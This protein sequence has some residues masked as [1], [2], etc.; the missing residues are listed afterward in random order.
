M[1]VTHIG[2]ALNRLGV[3]CDLEPTD[4]ICSAVVVLSIL[5]EGDSNPRLTIANSEGISWV[6][7]SGLLRIAERITSDPPP[8]ES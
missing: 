3:V 4:L 5:E 6:E 2:D 8:D 1:A 7:Q